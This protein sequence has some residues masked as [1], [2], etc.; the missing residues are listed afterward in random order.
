MMADL[1]KEYRKEFV[2]QCDEGSDVLPHGQQLRAFDAGLEPVAG[3]PRSDLQY[4]RPS[5]VVHAAADAARAFALPAIHRSQPKL[6]MKPTL[7]PAQALAWRVEA[8]CQVLS[9]QMLRLYGAKI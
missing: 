8:P 7:T 4:L 2:K 3:Q 6:T 1:G 5:G 9:I